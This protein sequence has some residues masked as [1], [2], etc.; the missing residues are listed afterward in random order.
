MNRKRTITFEYVCEYVDEYGDII[1]TDEGDKLSD[2]FP[3]SDERFCYPNLRPIYCIR[4]KSGFGDY[5][6]T[7]SYAYAG[8]HE[9]DSGHKVPKE[10]FNQ[11]LKTITPLS[12]S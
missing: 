7:T 4:R 3:N 12:I 2:V 1:D 5:D 8:E 9:F 10:K 6:V 11:L